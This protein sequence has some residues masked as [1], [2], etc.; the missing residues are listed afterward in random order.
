[1]NYH[2]VET[3]LTSILEKEEIEYG[4][5]TAQEWE[6]TEKTVNCIFPEEFKFFIQLMSEWIFQGIYTMSAKIIME[7]I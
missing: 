2:E 5:P 3:I 6:E 7:M 4:K 1:M